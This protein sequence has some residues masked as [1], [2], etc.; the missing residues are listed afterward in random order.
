M[1]RNRKNIRT[2]RKQI[3]L[4]KELQ[5]VKNKTKQK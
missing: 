3:K 5:E 2:Q 1:E 4:R